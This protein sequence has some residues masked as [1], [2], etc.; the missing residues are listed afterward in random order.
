VRNIRAISQATP[1]RTDNSAAYHTMPRPQFEPL[2]R[3]G[4]FR[5]IFQ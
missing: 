1:D 5:V 2:L 3:H 4:D